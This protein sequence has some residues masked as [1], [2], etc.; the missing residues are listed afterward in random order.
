[1]YSI[2][3]ISFSGASCQT[4]GSVNPLKTYT[5]PLKN[6]GQKF[7]NQKLSLCNPVN[8]LDEHNSTRAQNFKIRISLSVGHNVMS[9]KQPV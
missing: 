8:E 7:L 2:P 4:F 5:L 6:A 9:G 3:I 1:M